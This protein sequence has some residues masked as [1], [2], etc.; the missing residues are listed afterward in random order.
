MLQFKLHVIFKLLAMLFNI[1]ILDKLHK[2]L[3]V[4]TSHVTRKVTSVLSGKVILQTCLHSYQDKWS[5]NE[6]II[7][8]SLHKNICN[9]LAEAILMS[10]HI[11][12]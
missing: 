7:F 12:F 6:K 2:C 4:N 1:Y 10:T 9:H 5:D 3:S 8:V 11:Y